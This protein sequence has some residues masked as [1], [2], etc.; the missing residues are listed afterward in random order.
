Q[1]DATVGQLLTDLHAWLDA[2]ARVQ[3]YRQRAD[4]LHRDLARGAAGRAA[5]AIVERLERHR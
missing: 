5:D 4:A 2:P 1:Q 3:A